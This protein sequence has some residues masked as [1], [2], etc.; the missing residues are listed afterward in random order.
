[1]PSA[2]AELEHLTTAGV[3]AVR[4]ELV[5]RRFDDFVRAAWHTLHDEETEPLLWNQAMEAVCLHLQAVAEGRVNLL[6]VNI[7][8]GF[9]KSTL[10]SVLFNAWMLARTAGRWQQLAISAIETLTLELGQKVQTVVN[11]DWYQSTIRPGWT[12][13]WKTDAKEFYKITSG[14]ARWCRTVGQ[15]ITGVRPHTPGV[16]T[17]DDPLDASHAGSDSPDLV[18]CNQWFRT[19]LWSRR[20]IGR[21]KTPVILIMQRLHL[22][23]LTGML[24]NMRNR[25]WCHLSIPMM[26]DGR[27]KL[28]TLELGWTDWRTE[29]GQLID[30][31][32]FNAEDAADTIETLGRLRWNAQ[33]Q[34]Q[35]APDE[36]ALYRKE[37][38]A[39]WH[40]LPCPS[41]YPRAHE[42]G[43]ELAPWRWL[44][45]SC[46][47]TWTSTS[48]SD[49]AT[50]QVWGLYD[51]RAYLLDQVRAKLSP[52]AFA[53]RVR[54][55]RDR[56]T[57][58]GAQPTTTIVELKGSGKEVVNH[59]KQWIGAVTPYN[60]Q[61]V[62][63]IERANATLHWWETNRVMIPDPVEL[64]WVRDVYLPELLAFPNG[65]KDDQVDAGTQALLWFGSRLH[66][67]PYVANLG[68]PDAPP[69]I[70]GPMT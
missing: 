59:L 30:E 70:A 18:K 15:R 38:V 62:T 17:I 10:V 64:D 8:P 46:D 45:I 43:V 69:T 9:A 19:S 31:R 55:L 11:S 50:A 42:P 68:A 53:Q 52:Y 39:N 32:L 49:F 56:W 27:P 41:P 44:V 5:L 67:L 23:D 2:P 34:Q 66:G 48:D 21:I 14:G 33:Y 20:S 26:W 25:R 16:I 65:R 40:F 6:I 7:P 37:W 22:N 24:L 47:S 61:G 58:A 63:K 3:A 1:M 60:P 51:R 57:R 28:P 4:R 54:D 29:P 12:W 13:D 36:G 35:P